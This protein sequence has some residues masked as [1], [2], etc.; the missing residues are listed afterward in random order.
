MVDA[1]KQILLGGGVKWL[2]AVHEGPDTLFSLRS[3]T[4]NNSVHTSL[5]FPHRPKQSLGVNDYNYYC[6]AL[7]PVKILCP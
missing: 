2:N 5:S 6:L 7:K 3:S 4:H 1:Q